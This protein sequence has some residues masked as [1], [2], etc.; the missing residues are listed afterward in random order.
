MVM[1]QFKVDYAFFDV[2]HERYNII[3]KNIV[4][5]IICMSQHGAL[6]INDDLFDAFSY[7]LFW[8]LRQH[9]HKYFSEYCRYAVSEAEPG[10]DSCINRTYA[11]ANA[12]ERFPCIRT[13]IKGGHYNA[14]HVEKTYSYDPVN[15]VGFPLGVRIYRHNMNSGKNDKGEISITSETSFIDVGLDEIFAGKLPAPMLR[16]Q[17]DIT[18]SEIS[19][20]ISNKIN[21]TYFGGNREKIRASIIDISCSGFF[22]AQPDV[23][24]IPP[25]IGIG[26]RRKVSRRN[27]VTRRK[28]R[29]ERKERNKSKIIN[30][31]K[32]TRRSNRTRKNRRILS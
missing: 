7:A 15:D 2:S 6:K 1:N 23:P 13:I 22:Q 10:S 9:D 18:L 17:Y 19:L 3:Q 26:G 14:N 8:G 21:Q 11:L 32:R 5:A 28:E 20:V 31:I 16:G 30:R 12:Y 4:T 27:K 25:D 24:N 29:K